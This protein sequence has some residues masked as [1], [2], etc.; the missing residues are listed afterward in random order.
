MFSYSLHREGK[1]WDP[2]SADATV[3]RRVSMMLGQLGQLAVGEAQALTPAGV[4]GAARRG[5]KMVKTG[6]LS[7]TVTTDSAYSGF[8][9]TGTR[10]HMPPKGS[11]LLWVRRVLGVDEKRAASVE[12]LVRRGIARRGT[13]ARAGSKY[14]QLGASP[15]GGGTWAFTSAMKLIEGPGQKKFIAPLGFQL[16]RDLS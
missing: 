3:R 7:F 2:S 11:L 10:P 5:V 14:D 8:L 4:T 9:E 15:G 6:E 1:I 12:Y 13:S 16:V